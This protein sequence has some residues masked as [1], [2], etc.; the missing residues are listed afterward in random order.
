[1]ITT[2]DAGGPLEVVGDGCTGLVC[3]PTAAAIAEACE[4]LAQ[5]PEMARELG[6]RGKTQAEEVTWDRTIDKL[7]GA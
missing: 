4:R 6:S 7:L 2:R 1:V 3:E 5:H